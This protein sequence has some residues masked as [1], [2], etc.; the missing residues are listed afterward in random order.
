MQICCINFYFFLFISF[1]RQLH[2]SR[3]M[4][5][6][7]TRKISSLCGIDKSIHIV[8]AHSY[9][10]SIYASALCV[11]TRARYAPCC[12]RV[13]ISSSYIKN[14]AMPT[15]YCC[16][17]LLFCPYKKQDFAMKGTLPKIERAPLV[18]I[19]FMRLII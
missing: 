2:A 8:I 3:N 16:E 10:F 12:S 18:L 7:C 9:I 15:Q 13:L 17:F 4:Y 19:A 14:H 6:I 11:R 1:F 5:Q